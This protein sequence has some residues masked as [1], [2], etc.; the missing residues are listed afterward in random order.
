MSKQEDGSNGWPI[1]R[2]VLIWFPV[3]T[4]FVL[5]LI[6]Y[7]FYDVRFIVNLSKEPDEL[8]LLIFGFL[9]YSIPFI[10]TTYL[11][12][13]DMLSKVPFSRAVKQWLFRFL[14]ALALYSFLL[15]DVTRSAAMKLPGASTAPVV[16][17]LFPIMGSLLVFIGNCFVHN[18]SARNKSV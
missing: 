6:I 16:L 1:Y 17:M 4:G 5:P 3:L 12:R 7:S 14:P 11:T 10:I 2:S 18:R 8:I 15:I 9:L 13:R